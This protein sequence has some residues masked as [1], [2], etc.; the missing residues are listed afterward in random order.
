MAR[1]AP[2]SPWQ[3]IGRRPPYI[4]G[5]RGNTIEQSMQF[6]GMS[7]DFVETDLWVH[8]NRFESRHERALYPLPILF[9]KWYVKRRSGPYSLAETA[10]AIGERGWLFLDLKNGG[11]SVVPLIR[12][13]RERLPALPISA[14]GSDWGT[15]R[16]LSD[17]V[18]DIDVFYSMEVPER[19]DLFLSVI[20]RDLRPLGVSIR[21]RLLS[22]G[23]VE[24]L[25]GLGL[26]VVA[27]TVDEADR[28]RR[29]AG[30]GVDAITTHHPA[31]IREAVTL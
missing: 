2:G 24:H 21:A 20:E 19:L 18:P 6:L 8:R 11:E 10:E 1:P 28:A 25:H 12:E 7:A 27:W 15:L 3:E 17:G 29:L 5:H 23:L 9:E 30:W 22:K 31:E 4:I 16:A 26:R 14:S 13:T